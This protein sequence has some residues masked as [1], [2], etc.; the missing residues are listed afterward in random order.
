MRITGGAFRGRTLFAPADA[1]VRPT[2][3][4]VRQA[5]FNILAHNEFGVGFTLNGARVGDLFAGTGAMGIEA[6]SH[7]ARNCL[8]VEDATESR[9][10]IRKNVEALQLTGVTKIWRRDATQLGPMPGGSGGPFDLVF[11]DPPYHRNLIPKALASL[12]TG[13]WL[14]PNAVLIVETAESE[15]DLFPEEFLLLTQHVYGDTQ[16]HVVKQA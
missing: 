13:Q 6:L 2:A 16:V 12:T 15:A 8:F 4:K 7:G 3:D 9:A 10:L 14:A 5:I 11:L 1:R